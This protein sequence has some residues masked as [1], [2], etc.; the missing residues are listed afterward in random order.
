MPAVDPGFHPGLWHRSE[1]QRR[2]REQGIDEFGLIVP[3]YD[4]QAIF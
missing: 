1:A 4:H 2:H 3:G